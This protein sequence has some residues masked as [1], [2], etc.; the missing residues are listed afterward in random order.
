MVVINT[1]AKSKAKIQS[2]L[3]EGGGIAVLDFMKRHDPTSQLLDPFAEQLNAEHNIPLVKIDTEMAPDLL[4]EFPV[5]SI[6]SYAVVKENWNNVIHLMSC[7]DKEDVRKIFDTAIHNMG[8]DK[9]ETWHC[10]CF[11]DLLWT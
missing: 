6:P 3:E 1:T 2:V 9:W 5:D 11:T 7:N 8:I 4:K 10:S